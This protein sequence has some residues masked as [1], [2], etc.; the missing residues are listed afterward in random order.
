MDKPAEFQTRAGWS[1]VWWEVELWRGSS[2]QWSATLHGCQSGTVLGG[3]F[4][5]DGKTF[6]IMGDDQ[7]ISVSLTPGQA[8]SITG[9]AV[10]E[11]YVDIK[12]A[13]RVLWLRGKVTVG[14]N[15]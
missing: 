11:L 12:D 15:Q 3:L 8:D 13:G 5:V 7:V 9:G 14:D 1:P 10:A 4:V 6:P 2:W